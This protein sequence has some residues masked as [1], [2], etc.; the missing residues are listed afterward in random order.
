MLHAA[1]LMYVRGADIQERNEEHM[2]RRMTDTQTT[3]GRATKPTDRSFSFN[4]RCRRS[5]LHPGAK[6]MLPVPH[7]VHGGRKQAVTWPSG[8]A[9]RASVSKRC[10]A[11]R[12]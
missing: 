1:V 6:V 2:G 9:R 11:S 5:R 7:G 8:G 4:R 3:H 10:A 12:S